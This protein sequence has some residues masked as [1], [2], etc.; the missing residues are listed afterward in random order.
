MLVIKDLAWDS[1]LSATFA[2]AFGYQNQRLQPF[3]TN[4]ADTVYNTLGAAFNAT[5]P[6]A[7]PRQTSEAS[8]NSQNAQ[9]RWTA[10]PTDHLHLNMEYRLFRND[11]TTKRFVTANFVREDED[12]RT[13][14]NQCVEPCVAN[15]TFSSLPIGYTRQ[16]ATLNASY[17]FGHDNRLGLTY[18]LEN[19]DRNL[20]EV[21]Y[22]DDN[23]VRVSFDSK[24]KA[25]LDLKSW[26]EH[27]IRTTSVYN[28]NQGHDAEGDSQEF[29]ALP[30]LHKSDEAPYGKDDIQVIA[31]FTLN[32]SNSISTQGLFGRTVYNGQTFG[33]INNSHQAYGVDYT[34]D[35]NDRLSFFADYS[36]EKFHNR[37]E[38]RTFYPGGAC[39]PYSLAPGY[40]SYCNWG[41]VPE[42]TY[43]T[44]GVGMDAYFTP[45]FHTTI[46]FTF[47]KNNGVE[48]FSSILGPNSTVDPN[49]FTPLNFNN[50]DNVT[51]YTINQELEYKFSKTV[52]LSA[53]YQYEF[54]TNGD[55][56]YNGFSYVN[57][58]Q[59]FN[60]VP[61][62]AGI[63]GTNLLM[64]GLL[65]PGYHAN[66]AYF[67]LKFGL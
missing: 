61:F 3:S 8:I 2:A 48:K 52:Q 25:W 32:D 26:Y 59:S 19:W 14:T 4:T 35:A 31:T 41:G 10:K 1:T 42:D 23:K 64:G 7:L 16:T 34:Y 18:T 12:V 47:S 37:M 21:K 11:I 20:R 39:D 24:A 15:Y 58:Y 44:A 63:P 27:T 38:D 40:F 22:M 56:N 6:T 65:P 28:F 60:Y 29:S 62:N 43:N 13:P 9:V 57:Q 17:D 50:V 67:R 5:D 49:F 53:G 55:Y 33:L 51:Y 30:F 45:K 54:W 36:Y 46:Q 66:V